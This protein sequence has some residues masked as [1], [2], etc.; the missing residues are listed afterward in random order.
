MNLRKL[1]RPKESRV[2]LI[3]I[4][5]IGGSKDLTA[6]G[7]WTGQEGDTNFP[8]SKNQFGLSINTIIDWR[9]LAQNWIS[10]NRKLLRGF[11]FCHGRVCAVSMNIFTR[12]DFILTCEGEQDYFMTLFFLTRMNILYYFLN[13]RIEKIQK[14]SDV[15]WITEDNPLS[16]SKLRPLKCFPPLEH[17]VFP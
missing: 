2:F 7:R 5:Y 14:K 13:Q 11:Y 12:F 4:T 9:V 6:F 8:R 3:N 17:F 1:W 10:R 16:Y 15:Y